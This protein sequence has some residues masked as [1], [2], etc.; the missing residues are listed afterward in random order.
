MSEAAAEIE[1][2]PHVL[3]PAHQKLW[4]AA[5]QLLAANS[6]TTDK[7]LNRF[8]P[9]ITASASRVLVRTLTSL[10]SVQKVS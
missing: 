2:P 8:K 5:C 6:C 10:K 9:S 7:G 3:D 1:P 4:H